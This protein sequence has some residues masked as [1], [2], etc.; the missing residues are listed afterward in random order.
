MDKLVRQIEQS[1]I[2]QGEDEA[3]YYTLDTAD[4]GGSP[5]SV[6]VVVKLAGEDV[7]G[8]ILTGSP[9]VADDVI[10]MPKVA[11]VTNGSHYRLEIKFTTLSNV[12]EAWSELIGQE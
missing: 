6:S 4:W 5:S 8:D 11:N 7:S 12:V 3:V 2:Y 9:S 10:T 1:P